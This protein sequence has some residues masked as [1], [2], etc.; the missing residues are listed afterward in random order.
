MNIKAQYIE[1]NKE[2]QIE[3]DKVRNMFS[4]IYDY[5]DNMD[6]S[7]RESYLALA[8]LEEAQSWLIKGISRE[9]L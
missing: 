2:K 8:K 4:E 1:V 5:I 6:R 7:S 9:G 3:I